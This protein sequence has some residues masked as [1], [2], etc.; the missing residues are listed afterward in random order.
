MIHKIFLVNKYLQIYYFQ[1]ILRDENMKSSELVKQPTAHLNVV[2]PSY[3]TIT[4]SPH[5]NP[6]LINGRYYAFH[7]NVYDKKNNKIYLADVSRYIL[8]V[9]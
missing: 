8:I 1:V 7:V 6:S 2:E 9:N 5:N 3:L 4:I